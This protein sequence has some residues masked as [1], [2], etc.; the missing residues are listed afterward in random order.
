LQSESVE[1]LVPAI[2]EITI[3]S[4]L[5]AAR[6]PPTSRGQGLPHDGRARALAVIGTDRRTDWI[7]YSRAAPCRFVFNPAS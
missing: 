5:K 7:G 3:R 4:N 1:P 6:P 2:S